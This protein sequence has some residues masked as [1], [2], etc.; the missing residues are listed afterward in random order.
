MY[1]L[2]PTFIGSEVSLFAA[3]YWVAFEHF[4]RKFYTLPLDIEIWARFYVETP[5]R[6]YLSYPLLE[7]L[8]IQ[9]DHMIL[10]SRMQLFPDEFCQ[11]ELVKA[12]ENAFAKIY[13]LFHDKKL[14]LYA[15]QKSGQIRIW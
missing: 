9:S 15:T 4:P 13:A 3:I 7:K 1:L 2:T 14:R 6:D 10:N 12:Q 8:G 11:K 5:H